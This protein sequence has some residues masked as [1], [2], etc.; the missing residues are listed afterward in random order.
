MPIDQKTIEEMDKIVSSLSGKSPEATFNRSAL[1]PIK[2]R[3]AELRS[4]GNAFTRV[5]DDIRRRG[6]KVNQI[7]AGEGA[8]AGR[9][10]FGQVVK[11]TQET[12]GALSG[13]VYNLLPKKTREVLDKV[14]EGLGGAIN[15]I[16][17]KLND[18]NNESV[19]SEALRRYG[20][21]T[22]ENPEFGLKAEEALKIVQDIGLISGEVAGASTLPNVA[23][24]AGQKAS[25]L[26][27]KTTKRVKTAIE[28]SP[29]P[30]KSSIDSIRNRFKA[31]ETLPEQQ[32][33]LT[34]VYRDQVIGD[35]STIN[36][37][38]NTLAERN[39]TTP[40]ILLQEVIEEGGLP[41]VKGTKTS[42]QSFRDSVNREI[43]TGTE[44]INRRANQL[45]NTY[46][47][48]DIQAEAFDNILNA[49]ATTGQLTQMQNRIRSIIDNYRKKYGD[50]INTQTVNE[51]RVEMNKQ[52]KD[53]KP[54]ELDSNKAL[55]DTARRILRDADKD[56]SEALA[57][58]SKLNR[59]LDTTKALDLRKITV[60]EYVEKLGGAI[61]TIIAGAGGLTA[62]A[63]G[64]ASLLIAGAV[65]N[66]G[67]KILAR[68]LRK[69]AFSQKRLNLIKQS[70][71]ENPDIYKS[72]LEK[73][74]KVDRGYLEQ[75]LLPAPKEGAP[76][77]QQGSGTTIKVAPKGS[78]TEITGKNGIGDFTPKA[79]TITDSI[80]KEPANLNKII[81][82]AKAG[83]GGTLN[84]DGSIKEPT[85][86]YIVSIRSKNVPKDKLT[87]EEVLKFIEANKDIIDEFG[88]RI[89]I[90]TFDLGEDGLASIDIN[91]AVADEA[92]AVELAK[93]GRQQSVF[94]ESDFSL[95]ETGYSGK[96]PKKISK[97]DIQDLLDEF[98][99]DKIDIT[100]EDKLP[101]IK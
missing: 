24:K 55:G 51:L 23:T 9:S 101:V 98:S 34:K 33:D 3:I 80:K 35:N 86:D 68:A 15:A 7:L 2:D 65:T 22:A 54:F 5:R 87:N 16:S 99:D 44:L 92:L 28:K 42:F 95:I 83:E 63:G 72:M 71:D 31:S 26:A 67:A 52:I 59:V 49:R 58:Q 77:V 85:N 69:R 89:K 97:K 32:A 57:H 13:T 27:G 36:N 56:I 76:R 66:L 41:S 12:V 8:G 93:R 81:D 64:P 84:L 25:T 53:A 48:D 90:G 40:E 75:K 60:N 46:S 96:N 47:L 82:D 94:S 17:E 18:P 4:D 20:Q 19:V 91:L 6:D 21:K 37:K 79:K 10:E 78:Q 50:N 1:P 38:I 62:L 88:S 39:N 14:G 43:Q 70:L 11:A 45:K 61:G 100:P 29:I 30:V 73:A 74:D